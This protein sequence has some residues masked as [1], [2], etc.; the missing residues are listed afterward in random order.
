[1]KPFRLNEQLQGDRQIWYIAG[2]LS[3]ISVAAVYS[4]VAA[5]AARSIGATPQTIIAKHIAFLII[6]L[7]VMY[8]IHKQDFMNVAPYAKMLLLLAPVLIVY[9]LILGREV[10]GAKRWISVLGFTFQTSDFVRLILITNLA[11][12]LASKQNMKIERK[13]FM[14][15]IIWCGVLCG[16]LAFSSFSTAVILGLT[17]VLIMWIGRIPYKYLFGTLASVV[18]CLFVAISASW[19]ISN[20]TGK[21]IGRTQ[22]VIDRIE[23]FIKRDIDNSG[24]IGGTVGSTSSQMDEALLA[25]GR[26]GIFGVG[27]GNSAVKYKLPEAYSDFI[28]SIIV[29]EYGLLGGIVIMLLYL[30]L[31]LRGIWLVKH[32]SRPFAGLLSIG[33]TLSIVFQAFAHMFI[34]VGL[35]PVTGQTLPMIS[36]GG[37][38]ILFTAIAL[39]IVLSVSKEEMPKFSNN[40]Q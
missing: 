7:V 26:G 17:C 33:L 11:A 40:R 18:I 16:L 20:I 3:L 12:M 19:M 2:F 5:L 35:G 36:K 34:N 15:I 25:I 8:V 31:L 13:D 27:P 9:T 28:Y 29:E 39:G 14:P 1:M 32:S 23:V 38:S 6:G 21:E 4:S 30:W 24:L 37:T 22:T 10:G